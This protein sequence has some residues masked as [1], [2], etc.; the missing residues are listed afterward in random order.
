MVELTRKLMSA[1]GQD[2]EELQLRL[3]EVERQLAQRTA[4]LFGPS[5]EKRPRPTP[6]ER[7][8]LEE[9]TPRPCHGPRPQPT[10]PTLE[11][12]H[13]LDEPDKQCPRCGGALAP[14]VGCQEE[15]EEV[16]VV[17]R[18]SSSSATSGRSTAAAAAGAWRR[19]WARPSSRPAGATRWTSPWKWPWPNTSTTCP[20]SGRCESWSARGWWWTA[21]HS[22]T[23]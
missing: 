16:D 23:R 10:L 15:A 3:Q 17:Q 12:V 8:K 14:M 4:E 7:E 22:G 5:S 20:W 18:R 6:D 19:R 21:R 13:A 1:Q 11:V 9:A 2:A